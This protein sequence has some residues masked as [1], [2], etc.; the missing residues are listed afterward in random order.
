MKQSQTE[1]TP[2]PTPKNG[3]KFSLG[4]SVPSSIIGPARSLETDDIYPNDVNDHGQSIC[5]TTDLN[6][7]ISADGP[8]SLSL[9]GPVSAT[10]AYTN[11]IDGSPAP[12][13]K[14]LVDDVFGVLLPPRDQVPSA[15]RMV[16]VKGK[17]VDQATYHNQHNHPHFGAVSSVPANTTSPKCNHLRKDTPTPN[18]N[19]KL[20]GKG[21]NKWYQRHSTN[22]VHIT[23]HQISERD[24]DRDRDVVKLDRIKIYNL[25]QNQI[26]SLNQNRTPSPVPPEKRML[27]NTI[28]SSKISNFSKFD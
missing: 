26:Q 4:S 9:F 3:H 22:T 21:K 2:L 18:N 16:E 24:G 19:N 5:P 1:I 27:L 14:S 10:S 28:K 20:L 23:P 15:P 7:P 17:S 6:K 11:S 25:N 13:G 8:M 12:D